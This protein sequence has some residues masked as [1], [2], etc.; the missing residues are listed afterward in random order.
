MF[1]LK[2]IY[3]IFPVLIVYK[4]FL[5]KEQFEG[6]CYGPLIAIKSKSKNS[7]SLLEHELI[8]SKQTLRMLVLFHMLLYKFSRTYRL[9]AELEAYNA[10]V[11]ERGYNKYIIDWV[12]KILFNKYNLKMSKNEIEEIA[13]NYYNKKN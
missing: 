11:S 9:K 6:I 4:D 3:Y 8:H 5:V 12:I 2:F 10:Q 13:V 1:K 7:K